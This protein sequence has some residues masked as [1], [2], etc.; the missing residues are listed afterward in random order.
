MNAKLVRGLAVLA[1][2]LPCLVQAADERPS[3]PLRVVTPF[4]SGHL[5]AETG[6]RFQEALAQKAPHIK[7]SVQAG[8]LDEQRIDPAF[9]TC[10]ANARVGEI[11]LTG[12]QPIQDY[13][14]D[15]FFFNGP[16][17]IRDFAQLLS[18]WR[19]GT[20]A[21]MASLIEKNGNMVT[22]DPLYRGYRQFTANKPIRTPA[23]F[24]NVKLRLPPVPD[25]IS[26][27]QALEV[28][29]VQVPLPRIHEALG[30]GEAEAA[31]GDLS[32][33]SSLKL[34]EVQSTLILTRHLVGFGMPLA[35]ACFVR[36]ELDAADQK[37]VR[38]AMNEATAWATQYSEMSESAQ[39]DALRAAGMQVIT[40][41][42]DAIRRRAE[43]A[44]QQLFAKKWTVTRW[45]DVNAM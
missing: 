5:L 40:T 39:L 4:A 9:A 28:T 12:G 8:V 16:Y 34:H 45:S 18:L 36:K 26:V 32:Q 33:I 11:L 38:E 23:D 7:V 1:A 30:K 43:P 19:S 37:A 25:W 35:N 42:A 44:I 2:L 13:A 24:R 10:E 6:A 22:L 20:G 41:D 29:P 31:E 21:A 27:W 15:F 14:P 17:V 3:I